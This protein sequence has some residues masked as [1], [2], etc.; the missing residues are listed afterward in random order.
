MTL[1]DIEKAF[2]RVWKDG[3]IFKMIQYKYPN[4]LIKLIDNY[5][6]KRHL[7]VSV[8]DSKSTKR[9]IKT[10][11][12]QGSVLGPKLFNIYLNDIPQ[13]EKTKTALFADDTAIYAHS[14]NAIVAAKQL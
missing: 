3:L 13:F 14:F 12:P 9:K 6:T 7:I 5:L 1:L 8:N 11:V 10:G 4:T 2:D